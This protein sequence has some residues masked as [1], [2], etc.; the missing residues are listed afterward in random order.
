MKDQARAVVVGGGIM[1]VS[2]AYHLARMGWTDVVL[3][4]KGE[5]ATGESGFAAGLVTQ[6]HTSPTLM[7]IRKYSIEL[8]SELKLFHHV[9]SLRLASTPAQLKELQRNI[10]QARAIGLEVELISAAEAVKLFPMSDRELYGAIY[11]PRDGHLDPYGAT[12]GLAQHA[13][14]L[15]VTIHTGTRLTGIRL[16]PR[17]EVTHAVTDQGDI[18]TEVVVNAA[19]LW[20]PQV[21]AFA[22]VHIPSTP[23]DHQHIALKAVPGH[24]L[25]FET[26]CLRDPDNLIYLKEE[27]GGLVIGGY[28]LNPTARWVDGVPWE[29]GG[30]AL[31]PDFDQFDPILEGAIRR[32][33]FLEK[34]EVV[35][36]IRHPGAYTPDS[37]PM[38][39]PVPGARGL[40][41]AAGLSLNGFGGAGGMGKV[42]AE[43]IIEGEPSLDLASFHGW[44]FGRNYADPAYAAERTREGVK[45]YYYLR[46][47]NDENEWARPRRISPVHGRLQELGAVFGEK[48]GWERVNYLQPGQAWRRAGADQRDPAWQWGRPPYFERLRQEHLAVRQ[49]VGLFDMSSFG[50]V[51]VIGAGA[52]PLLQRLSDNNLDVP[53][54]KVVYTQFLNSRGGVIADLTITRMAADHFRVVTGSAFIGHDLGWIQMHL[55]PADGPVEVREVT[56]DLACLGL[57]G[58]RAR[59]VLQS[60]A[61]SDVSNQ[62]MPYMTGAEIRLAGFTS[63]AQR[64][65]YVGEL[66]WELYVP[67][68]RALPAWDALVSAARQHGLEVGGYKVLDCLRLEKGYRY[69]GMDVTMLETPYEA[70]LGFCVRLNKGDF[71]GR[72]ALQQARQTGLKKKLST[73]T[74]G[75]EEYLPLYGGEAVLQGKDVV[76][77]LR[78]AG[79]G[80]SANRNIAYSYLPVDLAAPGLELEIEMFGNRVAA[81]VAEDVLIDPEGKKLVA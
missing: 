47:P 13:R 26:P 54:G 68:E 51:E 3:I 74:I 48:N 61:D 20:G 66:G 30:Q 67:R 80:F 24:E 81:Q 42:L 1:G 23:V 14:Q 49:N 52:L 27:A 76:G 31:A 22:G 10:S 71:I 57:W 44:R 21:A 5:I 53:V 36:L 19:G 16:S 40:W 4:E 12:T 37:R 34:A 39:G 70:G 46:F 7:Q 6:F 56:E 63:F 50:K 32:I 45:Y 15:G 60:V 11:L 9:G 64:V 18:R 65:T 2:I 17:G 59:E 28:E 69:Y 75:T 43:W 77:R 8:F 29:H 73:L 58:P 25:P 72:G 35:S 38:L 55:D 79:Y 33:P 41:L 78:S 62:A